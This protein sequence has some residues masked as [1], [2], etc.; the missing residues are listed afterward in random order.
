MLPIR[1]QNNG[2]LTVAGRMLSL[3]LLA[4]FFAASVSAQAPQGLPDI[5]HMSI[6]EL[7]NVEV[8]SVSKR[9][10]R[11]ADAAAAEAVA[12]AIVEMGRRTMPASAGSAP[13]PAA[14]T[15]HG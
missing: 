15:L 8:T 3:M 6:E 2:S 14:R 9:P 13:S 4:L 10:Q 5:A 1:N 12:H 7:M 11:V